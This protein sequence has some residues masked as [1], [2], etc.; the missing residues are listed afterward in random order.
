LCIPRRIEAIDKITTLHIGTTK[1]GSTSIQSFLAGNREY[2]A[3]KGVIFPKALGAANHNAIPVY[4]Q[5]KWVMNRLQSRQNVKSAEDY[6]A[7]KKMLPEMLVNEVAHLNPDHFIISNEHMHSRCYKPAHFRRL[8]TLLKP[9]L[10]NRRIQIVIYLRPQIAHVISL[11]STMLHHGLT[12]TVDE[13]IESKMSGRAHEYFDFQ[14]LLNVWKTAFPD[15][16]FIVR[17]FTQMG[18]LPHGV[19]SDFLELTQLAQFADEM[20]F[21]ARKNESMS[22]WAAEAL[23]QLNTMDIPLS[24]PLG[25]RT[26]HWLRFEIPAGR[27][28]PNM[29][30]ARKFQESYTNGNHE[31]C[32]TYFNGDTTVLDVDWSKYEADAD[33]QG[34]KPE[35]LITLLTEAEA[36]GTKSGQLTKLLAETAKE[37]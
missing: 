3:E 37:L 2:L 9:V 23:R 30:V 34:F 5:G 4:V 26:R 27:V 18:T 15:A 29:D 25:N 22:P 28:I 33:T 11:Y 12:A 16:T 20:T 13:F 10:T 31:T 32:K 7:F 1:T 17:P 8:K 36:Q 14:S 21:G 19:L 35:Q 24:P 6:A